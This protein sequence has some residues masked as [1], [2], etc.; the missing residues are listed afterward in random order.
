MKGRRFLRAVVLGLAA[1]SSPAAPLDAQDAAAGPS[2]M[3]LQIIVVDSHEQAERLH[4]S[5]GRGADFAAL[6]MR[7]SLDPSADN[8]GHLGELDSS[9]LHPALQPILRSLPPGG[10]TGAFKL[11]TGRGYAIV[12]RLGSDDLVLFGQ[13]DDAAPQAMSSAAA[14]PLTGRAVVREPPNTSG[15]VNVEAAFREFPKPDGWDRD[16]HAI[17]AIR[18]DMLTTVTGRLRNL[19]G[20]GSRAL[21]VMSPRQELHARSL[22]GLFESYQGFMGRAIDRFEETYAIAQTS[23]P[24]AIPI[25]EEMLGSTYFHAA[26]MANGVYTRPDDRCLFPQP[27]GTPAFHEP[28]HARKAVEY[29]TRYLEKKPADL[30]VRWLLNLAYVTLGEYP[31]RVPADYLVPPVLFASPEGVGR[32]VDV[33]REAGLGDSVFVSPALV[34]DDIDGDGLIDVVVASYDVCEHLR[35]YRNNG[36]GTFTDRTPRRGS[37]RLPAARAWTRPTTTT[38][39]AW[40]C[41]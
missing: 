37:P 11:P 31:D 34:A 30:E 40:T 15:L 28:G 7:D 12:K 41:W 1:L 8:G 25:L 20:P 27:A 26:E 10:V 3:Y 33:A 5:L 6:A 32:F 21:E 14:L 24:A 13:S 22:A 9:S 23:V 16:P 29:F 36:D 35:F 4:A 38:T 17:C 19:T 39:A 2:T 18:Q